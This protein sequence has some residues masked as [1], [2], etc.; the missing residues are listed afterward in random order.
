[1]RKTLKEYFPMIRSREEVYQ[2]I[3]NKQH[4]RKIYES[5]NEEQQKYFLDICSGARGV[6]MLYDGFFK[7][8]INPETVPE[9]R[10]P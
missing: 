3:Q 4:L 1:M 9:Q 10:A 6:K 8:I 2:E 7:E 5:W